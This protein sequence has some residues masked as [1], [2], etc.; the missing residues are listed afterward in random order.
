MEALTKSFASIVEKLNNDPKSE[1]YW[2]NQTLTIQLQNV[3]EEFQ[4]FTPWILLKNAPLKFADFGALH[5]NASLI[6]FVKTA[7]ELQAKVNLQQASA[8]M[9]EENEWLQLLQ[10]A[11]TKS[12]HKADEK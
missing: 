9:P 3:R 10:T 8:N 1:A 7:R 12:I 5:A 2:W 11:L 4:I 6:E